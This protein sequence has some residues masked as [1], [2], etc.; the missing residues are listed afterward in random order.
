ML[1]K[2]SSLIGQLDPVRICDWLTKVK[3]IF[4]HGMILWK[5]KRFPFG[6]VN[7][8]EIKWHLQSQMLISFI[9]IVLISYVMFQ[10]FGLN[11]NFQMIYMSFVYFWIKQKKIWILASFLYTP[12]ISPLQLWHICQANLSQWNYLMPNNLFISRRTA[13]QNPTHPTCINMW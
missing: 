5:D 9:V 3:W 10:L 1:Q 4:E 12:W 8:I 7:F 6:L 11:V 2:S 13:T